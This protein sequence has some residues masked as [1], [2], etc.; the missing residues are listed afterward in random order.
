M[1]T[2]ME[3][4][5]IS[6]ALIKIF[7]QSQPSLDLLMKV[8]FNDKAYHTYSSICIFQ[9]VCICAHLSKNP[10][11]LSNFFLFF[12]QY[13]LCPR[14]SSP[15]LWSIMVSSFGITALESRENKEIKL[16]SDYT[17][18]ILQVLTFAAITSVWISLQS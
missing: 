16:Y 11:Q 18:N 2:S 8:E 13:L 6:V 3:K 10:T 17:K 5:Q 1:F 12:Q 4:N 7:S 9:P 15:K 14:N